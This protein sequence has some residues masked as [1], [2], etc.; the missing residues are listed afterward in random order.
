MTTYDNLLLKIKPQPI[1]TESDYRRTLRQLDELMEPHPPRDVAKMIDML[2]VLVERYE[3]THFPARRRLSPAEY[4][5]ELIEARNVTQAEVSRKA[6]V[7]P[8]VLSS[9]LAGRRQISKVNALRLA[10]FF[11]VPAEWFVGDAIGAQ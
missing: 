7:P 4:L 3:S 9:V 6:D 2:A 8:S 5:R 1:R 11:R 10:K